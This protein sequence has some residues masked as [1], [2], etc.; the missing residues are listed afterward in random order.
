MTGMPQAEKPKVTPKAGGLLLEWPK[1]GVKIDVSR[2]HAHKDGRV[3]GEL[4]IS[5]DLPGI[6]PML[7]PPSQYNFVAATSMKGLAKDMAEKLPDADW[8]SIT[9]QLSWYCT[10]AARLGEPMQ[11]LS[12]E[13][14]IKP[15]EYAI[16]PIAPKGKP[17]ILF[18]DGGSGKSRLALV[19]GVA[20]MLPWHDNPMGLRMPE[21]SSPLLVLDWESD[22]EDWR[23]NMKR[24]QRGM[25]LPPLFWN[26]RRCSIPLADDIAAIA[27]MVEQS[28]AKMAIVDSLGPASGGE[29]NDS[30]PAIRFFAALRQLRLTSLVVAHTSKKD[31][32][33][34]SIYGNVF[35]KNLARSVWE[36]RC[37]QAEA[38]IDSDE[39][40]IAMFH[41]KANVSK[42]FPPLGYCFRFSSEEGAE[43][44]MVGQQDTRSVD[45]F[46]AQMGTGVR[47]MQALKN[48]S[49]TKEEL[50]AEL[51]ATSEAIRSAIRR[52]DKGKRLVHLEGGKYG[53]STKA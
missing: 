20:A 11:E 34:K 53:L 43:A 26:Y 18:G 50:M 2:L 8:A 29:L 14:E 31:E 28:K 37:Q 36:I 39:L 32:K 22:E 48:G 1:Q 51:S 41:R 3:T 23:W 47:I 33:S 38:E 17:T 10:Q 24:L 27:E 35:F 7:L 30:E 49:M 42:K 44:F 9:G 52:L 19:L 12:T 21:D 16:W 45:E 46:L 25:D 5:T 4:I 15:P 13:D 6:G 40:N